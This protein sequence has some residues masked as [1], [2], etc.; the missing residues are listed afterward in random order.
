MKGKCAKVRK[1]PAVKYPVDKKELQYTL[2]GFEKA[3][4]VLCSNCS[5]TEQ[6]Y[7]SK[8]IGMHLAYS[9]EMRLS[10]IHSYRLAMPV[11]VKDSTIFAL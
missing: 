3:A 11:L 2:L 6:I 5:R 7:Q 9:L 4:T 1:F 10:I 8:Q